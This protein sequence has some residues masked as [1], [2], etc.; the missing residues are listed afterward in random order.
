MPTPTRSFFDVAA[1]YGN[2][3]PSDPEAVHDWYTDVLPN[4]PPETVEE[5]LEILV[6]G[7][8]TS[9]EGET[10]R[11]YPKGVPLPS[12]SASPAVQIPLLAAGWRE[13][14]NKLTGRR[15]ET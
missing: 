12:L 3:D 9:A 14:L 15:R 11:S 10:T 7:E 1:Q 5:I 6:E 4:L 13:L 2:V 8:G